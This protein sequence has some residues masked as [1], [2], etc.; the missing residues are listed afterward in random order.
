MDQQK[1]LQTLSCTEHKQDSLEEQKVQSLL[2][3][4]H[5]GSDLAEDDASFNSMRLDL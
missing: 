1:I 2:T 3:E 4:L 5:L